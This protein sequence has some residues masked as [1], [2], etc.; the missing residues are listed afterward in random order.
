MYPVLEQ[1]AN[2]DRAEK[3]VPSSRRRICLIFCRSL[4]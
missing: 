3:A 2:T 1:L 4:Q